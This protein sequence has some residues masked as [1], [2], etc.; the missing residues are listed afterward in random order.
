MAKK[1]PGDVL[2]GDWNPVI[3]CE[4]CSAGCRACWYLDGIFPWQQRLGN[5]PAGVRP[6]ESHA[7]PKRL[8]E[9][10]LYPKNGIVGVVQ[11]GDLFWD[12]VSEATIDQVLSIVDAVAARK[13]GTPKYLLWTKRARRLAEVLTRRY[14][15]GLPDYLAVAVSVENQA[16]ADERLPELARVKGTRVV[17]LEPLLGPVDLSAHLPLEWIILGSE[18]GKRARPLDLEWARAIRDQAKALGIPFF[19]KQLGT[20]HKD[21]LR[22]LDGRTWDEFP[23]GFEK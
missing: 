20:S 2:S 1:N 6:D 13:R 8:S 3:G 23:E 15:A 14:P 16:T 9:E 17:V 5:I 4:R 19:I 18:T 11:H 7:F 21:Q 10:A 12:K 22:V